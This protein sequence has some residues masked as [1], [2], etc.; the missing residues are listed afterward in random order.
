MDIIRGSKIYKS[1][2]QQPRP[3]FIVHVLKRGL[4]LDLLCQ[5]PHASNRTL[6]FPSIPLHAYNCPLPDG[7]VTEVNKVTDQRVTLLPPEP[8][9]VGLEFNVVTS[10]SER[11]N[12]D[13]EC[14]YNVR[15][16]I[17]DKGLPLLGAFRL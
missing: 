12:I 13:H 9:C 17:A 10:T 15:E 11:N 4:P 14:E 3:F 16:C 2:F 7:L 8:D 5:T 1:T 6:Q